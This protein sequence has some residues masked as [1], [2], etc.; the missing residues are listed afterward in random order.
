MDAFSILPSSLLR[1]SPSSMD[2]SL[3]LELVVSTSKLAAARH[4]LTLLGF[5]LKQMK[6]EVAR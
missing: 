1:K 2:S 4:K 6:K 3:G 5:E